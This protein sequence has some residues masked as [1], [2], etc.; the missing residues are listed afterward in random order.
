VSWQPEQQTL[1]ESLADMTTSPRTC[2]PMLSGQPSKI[3]PL[4]AW[5]KQQALAAKLAARLADVMTCN[6]PM[7]AYHAAPKNKAAPSLV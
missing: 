4:Q 7:K 2:Q 1:A 6:V 3:S 5:G